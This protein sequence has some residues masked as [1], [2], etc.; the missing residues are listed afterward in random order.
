MTLAIRPR[1]GLKVKVTYKDFGLEKILKNIGETSAKSVNV[2]VVGPKASEPAGRDGRITNGEDAIIQQYG[3]ARIPPRPFLTQP[4]EMHEGKRRVVQGFRQVVKGIVEH[5][6]PVDIALDDFGKKMSNLIQEE[7]VTSGNFTPNALLTIEK[8]GF[9]HPLIETA[10]LAEAISHRI[11]RKEFGDALEA[12]A[13]VGDY[14]AF[15]LSSESMDNRYYESF[16]VEG[17]D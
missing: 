17:G 14:E 9:D 5:G 8:K 10:G 3:T 6:T 13:A 16:S 15:V 1:G 4:F 12:G 2:G 11:V 7:M